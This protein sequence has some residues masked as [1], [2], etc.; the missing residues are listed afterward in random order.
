[1][2]LPAGLP[3]GGLAVVCHELRRPLTVIRGAATLLLESHDQLP[4]DS[5][6]RLLALI[7]RGARTMSD[8]VEDLA[9]VGRL[10]T[11]DLQVAMET[12]PAAGVMAA[13][14]EAEA[15]SHPDSEPPPVEPTDLEVEAD[16]EQAVR[17]LRMLLSRALEASAGDHLP[18][19]FA[20]A[21]GR[22]VSILV[23]LPA[24][25][26]DEGAGHGLYLARGLARLMSGEV[27]LRELPGGE[28]AYSFT[29]NRRV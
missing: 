4:A 27:A 1:M 22:R 12:V 5:R 17:A 16:R 24:A 15:R 7:D 14:V 25:P 28:L 8:L 13:A 29:L 6:A 19:L 26:A 10:E 23:T 2:N 9:V 20:E 3:A 21:S 18:R 11:G